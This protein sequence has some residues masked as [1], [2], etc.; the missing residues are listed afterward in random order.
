VYMRIWNLTINDPLCLPLAADARITPPDYTDDQ[1][2][3]FALAERD[4]QAL[5]LTTTY[6]LRARSIRLFPQFILNN[7]V[8]TNPYDFHKQPVFKS[9]YPNYLELSFSPFT[10]IDVLMEYWVPESKVIAGRINIIN[11]NNTNRMLFI[12]WTGILNPSSGERF[13]HNKEQTATILSG[14]SDDLIPVVFVTNGPK[15][16]SG[17]YPSLQL[18]F[19]LTPKKSMFF[20]WS[21][22]ALRDKESSFTTARGIATRKWDSERARIELTNQGQIEIYTGEPDWDA[23]FMLSQNIVN[24]L[25]FGP[26]NH[27]P[28]PS[29]VLN[30]TPDQGFSLRGDGSD[31]NHMWNG[32]T[33]LDTYFLLDYLLPSSLDV[34]KGIVENFFSVQDDTGFIDWKPG[35]A[36]QKSN[37]LATPILATL[38][39]RIFEFN[40]NLNFLEKAFTRLLKFSDC[41]FSELHDRDKDGIPEWDHP[42][43]TGYE[44]NPNYSQWDRRYLGIDIQTSESPSL[45]SFLYQEC[46]TL[47]K[48]AKTLGQIETIPFLEHKLK[49]LQDSLNEFWR[50]DEKFFSDRDRD[51]HLSS[52]NLLLGKQTGPGILILDANFDLPSRLLFHIE[53]KD[54]TRRNPTIFIYGYGASGKHR[55]EQVKSDEITWHLGTGRITGKHQYKKISQIEIRNLNPEDIFL[56]YNAGYRTINQ[57]SF[58]P[59]WAGISDIEK[60]QQL[61]N[62]HIVN[63]EMFW[64]P[65]GIPFA[66]P[67]QLFIEE[68]RSNLI[69]V[70]WNSIIG[71]G[72]LQYG[73]HNFAAELVEKLMNA[74]ILN[75]K[76]DR[77]FR[78]HYDAENGTGVGEKNAL[79]GLA[80]LGLFMETL[81]VHIYSPHRI[82]I[83]GVNPYKWPVIINYRG[84]SITRENEK[85]IINFR[86]GHTFEN[87][88]PEPKLITI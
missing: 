46:I 23:A 4:P 81:G 75:L 16:A 28:Y 29:F 42:L 53:T 87:S 32:Q 58:I 41:W 5:S 39:W 31:Y 30:R 66:Q 44:D 82:A 69:S 70:Q 33:S 51:S 64:K 40:Q 2:W 77:N 6:G 68:D 9:I 25:I 56:I 11:H 67:K 72:L 71:K 62:N 1:I 79:T 65:F 34:A 3:E 26:S 37:L 36:G 76:T 59:L 50:P 20:I 35:I 18:E 54:A 86:D 47:I 73:H 15:S 57:T 14:I 84:T 24:G 63:P 55:V 22:A 21:H 27:L 43:Q 7:T 13:S 10:G 60:A 12:N 80:P 74:V 48:I 49:V 78:Q 17:S 88:D 61:I 19:E 45:C 38:T 8:R 85:T 83:E 52:E